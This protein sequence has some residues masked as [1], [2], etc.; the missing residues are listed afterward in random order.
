MC[1]LVSIY[2][3]HTV[4]L[5]TN[6]SILCKKNKFALVCKRKDHSSVNNSLLIDSNSLGRNVE[7]WEIEKVFL[8][9]FKQ[10]YINF[11]S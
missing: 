3:I 8:Q 11:N 1:E 5:Q 4:I 9:N 7:S 10:A 6:Q 2:K